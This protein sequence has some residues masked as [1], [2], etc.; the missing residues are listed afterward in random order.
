LPVWKIFR[1]GR[2]GMDEALVAYDTGHADGRSGRDDARRAADSATGP[3]YRVGVL[4]GQVAAFE[5]ALI[6]AVRRALG[7]KLGEQHGEKA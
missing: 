2:D 6:S 7:E 3:D 1:E 5:E 4:D